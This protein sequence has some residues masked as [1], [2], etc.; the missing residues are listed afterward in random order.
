[1][2]RYNEMVETVRSLN[3]NRNR[4]AQQEAA[5]IDKAVNERSNFRNNYYQIK[6]SQHQQRMM[7][8]KIL[9]S[10]R[11]DAL[12]TCLKAIYIT[13][14]EANTLTDHSII[15]AE[16]M[17]DN[18]IKENGGAS[19]ILG[20]V[21]NNSYLLSRITDIVE[22]AALR[23]AEEIEKDDD[24]EDAKAA[25]DN[26]KDLQDK[27]LIAAKDFIDS[28]SEDDIK[29]FTAKMKGEAADDEDE[30]DDI[31]LPK[32]DDDKQDTPD[33]EDP[34]DDDDSDDDK[35]DD[36]KDSEDE[37]DDKDDSLNM[38]FDDDDSD[39]DKSDDKK[40]SED[41]DDEDDDDLGE[42]LPGED[43]DESSDDDNK[44]DSDKSSDD[45]DSEGKG[46]I[47]DNLDKEEDVQK[48]IDTI[49]NRVA[50]AEETFIKNNADDK[51]KID[52]LLTKISTNVKTV[53]DLNNKEDPKSK[54]A[55]ESV[56]MAKRQIDMIKT[57]R[58]L[59][60]FEK[61]TRN[62]SL[63]IV[64][65]C[66]VRESFIEEHGQLDVDMIV[67]TAKVMY[68]FLETVNTLQLEKVD[69]AYIKNVLENM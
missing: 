57:N 16:S 32:N 11:N 48:A 31:K 24:K 36:K 8:S 53:N 14:L 46:K 51:K 29:K 5:K 39:D 9:E 25:E 55:Q 50:D 56:Q 13:A 65:D 49:R 19:A 54:I 44:D 27:A 37:D 1:M 67:E 2:S 58:P 17:V 20:R 7:R 38:S 63:N 30:D 66:A 64:K 45:N 41:D 3:E 68:G 12:S 22:E 40:D 43:D 10:A 26:K 42:P 21:G 52:E 33:L 23:E 61:M 59:T 6:E 35:S 47:L 69:E 4:L 34:D 15:L 18:Y 62:L 28:A 60:I